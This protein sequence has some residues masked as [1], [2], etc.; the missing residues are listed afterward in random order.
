M[1]ISVLCSFVQLAFWTFILFP[2]AQRIQ[3]CDAQVQVYRL[4]L[5]CAINEK[6]KNVAASYVCMDF[7]EC[8]RR[9]VAIFDA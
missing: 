8:Q 3:Q 9:K 6:F 4:S 1:P 2:V 5:R 7:C